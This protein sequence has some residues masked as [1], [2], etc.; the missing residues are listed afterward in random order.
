MQGDSY[1]RE[2]VVSVLTDSNVNSEYEDED[3]AE[4]KKNMETLHDQ[5]TNAFK[6]NGLALVELDLSLNKPKTLLNNIIDLMTLKS[7]EVASNKLAN[8]SLG[9]SSL[10]NLQT[11]DVLNNIL[12]SWK[13]MKLFSMMTLRELNA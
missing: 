13:S 2:V 3:A 12:M 1:P 10:S 5:S 11:I 6:R 4:I 9:I 7:L 8:F